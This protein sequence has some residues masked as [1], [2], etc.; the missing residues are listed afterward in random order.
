[1]KYLSGL[2][3]GTLGKS[4]GALC[5]QG[6]VSVGNFATN[7]VLARQLPPAEYGTYVLI[8]AA[9]LVANGIHNAAIV[10]PLMVKV[11]PASPDSQR[12]YA[13]G[14]LA[15][16]AVFS[17]VAVAIVM[18]G[19]ISLHRV[20]V[21]ALAAFAA[22]AWQLQETV[23]RAMFAQRRNMEAIWGDFIS[24]PGQ[25]VAVMVLAHL[26]LLTLERAFIALALTS[27]L[28]AAVQTVQIQASAI[29]S[30]E[31]V[32]QVREFWTMARWMLGAAVLGG[33]TAQIFPWALAATHDRVYAATFQAL[34]NV[35]GVTHPV[36]LSIAA[37]I[38]PAIAALKGDRK[39]HSARRIA[40]MYT[41]QIEALLAP[42]FLVLLCWPGRVLTLFYG[43]SS[44]YVV[45]TTA[46]RL[47]VLLYVI[48][49]PMSVWGGAL[50]GAEEVRAGFRV[51]V[52]G[53]ILSAVIG[54]PLCFW[55]GLV[56]AITGDSSVRLV[57]A[58]KA[59]RTFVGGNENMLR[60][61]AL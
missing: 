35:L 19:A 24:Y 4:I 16:T 10:S 23:R 57:R 38:I 50:T 43:S 27:L 37:V 32:I 6:V 40:W 9:A 55:F 48:T 26:H 42:Y 29:R 61:T 60:R 22:V 46:L 47:M 5:D 59:W 34:I 28:A 53:V 31:L 14:S 51:Q 45:Q 1:M 17:V 21:G 41:L 44:P 3:G 56:G 49:V 33:V 13:T 11:A 25:A 20:E 8:S 18:F 39:S 30:G 15:M 54:I 36:I 2:L 7:V 12:K 58:V 52:W